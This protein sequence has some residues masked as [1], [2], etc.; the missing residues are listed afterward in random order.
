[1]GTKASRGTLQNPHHDHARPVHCRPSPINRQAHY[2]FRLQSAYPH[3]KHCVHLRPIDD[4]YQNVVNYRL[5]IVPAVPIMEFED[6]FG[7]WAS[8]FEIS[9]PYTELTLAAESTIALSGVDPFAFTH[10]PIRP[11]FPLVWMPWEHMML[12]PYLAPVELPETQ[13]RE[14]YDYA[15]SFVAAQQP[16]PDGN[17]FCHQPHAVSRIQVCPRQHRTGNHA[18]RGVHQQERG[19]P[20]FRQLVHLHGPACLAFPRAMS[21]ATFTPAT[22]APP[23]P[24]R[25]PRM[26]GCSCTFPRWAGKDSIPPTACWKAPITSAWL[27]ADIIAMPRPPREHSTPLARETMT[28]DVRVVESAMSSFTGVPSL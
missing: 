28:I 9:Q 1:M 4:V 10:A 2:S 22:R 24:G 11:S 14:L 3:S 5:Q 8:R 21:A 23:M 16:R 26:P 18:L 19:L 15:M 6:V 12:F 27:M 17:A 20:G 7:N 13:L 25:T